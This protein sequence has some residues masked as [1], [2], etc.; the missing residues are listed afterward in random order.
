MR[1][2]GTLV[3]P[4]AVLLALGCVCFA[5]LVHH[6]SGLIVDGARPS[7][8]FANHGDRRPVGNDATFV[9]LPHH[10][11][12]AKV[13]A[14]FGHLPGWDSSGFGGRPMVGNPQAGLFYPPVWIAWFSPYASTLGWL[15][16]VHLLWGGLGVYL[17]AKAQ[18]MGPWPAT[19]AA[20]IYQASPYLLAQT[21]EGHYPH[22][23]A[24]SW[25]P[26]AFWAQAEHRN[27][28]MR[29]LLALS[30]HPGDRLPDRA[31]ARVVSSGSCPLGLGCCRR[32]S[33]A[34]AR[35]G[36]AA[37]R[38]CDCH[39]LDHRAGGCPGPGRD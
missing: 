17:L 36:E 28:R 31:S 37:K 25:F 4:C 13:L 3:A 34:L 14:R 27:G 11:Y 16:V 35:P 19:V 23:W 1:R 29:G 18:G 38:S 10:L 6:P 39:S 8:D 21:F 26:W 32:S 5:R 12:V 33:A 30:T 2:Y 9:F 15:T 20:G 24:A 7:V 22:V